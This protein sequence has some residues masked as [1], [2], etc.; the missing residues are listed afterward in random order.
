MKITLEW[1][2]EKCICKEALKEFE[3]EIKQKLSPL[4]ALDIL[5]KKDKLEWANWLIVRCMNYKQCVS[6]AVFAAEQVID[7]YEKRYP[8]DDRPRKAIEAAKKCIT[9]PSVEN[10]KAA[11]SAADDV[12]TYNDDDNVA[13]AAS[14]YAAFTA[15]AAAMACAVSVRKKMRLKI[16]NY[17]IEL[18]KK[19]A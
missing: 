3:K 12:F 17:G 15:A 11:V 10:K 14:A 7:I 19:E 1:L 8:N 13:A 4:E 9:D 2:K 6:Y 5:I 18:L 16:L